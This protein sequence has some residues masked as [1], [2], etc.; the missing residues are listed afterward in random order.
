MD[1]P[2]LPQSCFSLRPD[3]PVQPNDAVWHPV[4]LKHFDNLPP[5]VCV[6]LARKARR[7]MT[8][9]EISKASGLSLRKVE[10]IAP[11]L[12]W[13]DVKIRDA[14]AFSQAC[15]VDL[16][17]QAAARYY[18]ARQRKVR[19]VFSHLTDRQLDQFIRLSAVRAKSIS[20][21]SSPASQ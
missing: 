7:R 9:P 17:N 6:A 1:V 21:P 20:A 3:L 13:K 5:F 10:R 12:S 2:L 18:L 8:L 11:A 14:E 16:V 15:G 4:V 19:Q